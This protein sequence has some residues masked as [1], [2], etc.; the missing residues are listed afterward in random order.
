MTNA[1]LQL[2]IDAANA[3]INARA[4]RE[5]TCWD[6][7]DSGHQQQITDIGKRINKC[8]RYMR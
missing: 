4:E 1:E 7:G 3:E 5:N 8:M 6:G 2:R